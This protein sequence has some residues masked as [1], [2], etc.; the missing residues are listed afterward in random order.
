MVYVTLILRLSGSSLI[1]IDLPLLLARLGN[2]QLKLSWAAA[3]F[4]AWL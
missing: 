2:S 1:K 4:V 3:L